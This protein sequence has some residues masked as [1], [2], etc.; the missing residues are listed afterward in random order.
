MCLLLSILIFFVPKDID[1]L[2][3][4]SPTQKEYPGA[5]ALILLDRKI[6]EVYNDYST[7]TTRH[8]IVKIFDDRG[9]SEYGDIKERY[10]NKTNEFQ[11]I[12]ARTHTPDGKE[13]PVSLDAITDLSAPEVADAPAYT[14]ARMRVISFPALEPNAVIEL[15]Y[16]IVPKKQNWVTKI[17]KKEEKH[18]FGE[19]LFGG[20]EPILKKEFKLI[21]PK[22]IEF[23]Y[24]LVNGDIEPNIENTGTKIIYAWMFENIPAIVSEP[25]MPPIEEIAPRLIFSSFDSWDRLAKWLTDRFYKNL[26]VNRELIYTIWKL[27]QNKSEEEIIRDCFL[28]VTTQIRNIELPV[29]LAGY[30]PNSAL[31]V[32]A[33]KYGD[34]MDK[35]I[36]LCTFL[37]EAGI[38]AFPVFVNTK[39]VTV[40]KDVASPSMFNHIIVAIQGA[41]GYFLMDPQATDT[42]FGYLPEE[43]QGVEGFILFKEDFEVKRTLTMPKEANLSYS[44]LKLSLS[45]DGD[46]EGEIYTELSGCYDRRARRCL[47]NKTNQ[48]KEMWIQGIMSLIATNVKLISCSISNL[49]DL[50]MPVD[51][52]A[53]FEAKG[54]AS[55]NNGTIQLLLPSNPFGFATPSNYVSLSERK[56]PLIM[57]PPRVIQY[58][59]ELELPEGFAVDYLPQNLSSENEFAKVYLCCSTDK[60]ILY[61]SE[62]V[63]KKHRIEPNEYQDFKSVVNEFLKP[64]TRMIILKRSCKD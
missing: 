20:N 43:A 34:P 11:V 22:N 44:R 13:I 45:E 26:K 48:E 41:M 29:G 27:T 4:D 36:L 10:N 3:K 49:N 8:L 25:Y 50:T 19:V 1:Q 6:I 40:V 56:Y 39:D 62:L 63:F 51:M 37:K 42:R 2:I 52:H 24:K 30:T 18:F 7:S 47:K 53:Y 64:K 28:Y 21:L 12:T 55:V 16:K 35:A 14:N 58:Q 23:K 5:G 59:V 32:Y 46:L 38:E 33:N 60:K 31:K 15:E 9:K 57:P 61:N 17:F 54:F